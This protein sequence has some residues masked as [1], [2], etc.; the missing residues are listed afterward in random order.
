MRIPLNILREQ[1][2]F[3][4]LNLSITFTVC[5]LAFIASFRASTV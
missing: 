5:S 3:N 4:Y 1:L 2:D